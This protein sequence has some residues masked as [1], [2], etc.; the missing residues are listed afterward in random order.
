MSLWAAPW[1][2]MHDI[3]L[4]FQHDL[5]GIERDGPI[6]AGYQ[7]RFEPGNLEK[8]SPILVRRLYTVSYTP[9]RA[10][11]IVYI[12]ST[13]HDNRNS[14]SPSHQYS[15]MP[16]KKRRPQGYKSKANEPRRRCRLAANASG[17][18]KEKKKELFRAP[19][20]LV[21][22]LLLLDSARELAPDL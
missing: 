20:H 14:S 21:L 7:Q 13:E 17:R 19:H 2:D 15:K 6:D 1:G 4:I 8:K 3:N 12:I 18:K 9:L 16:N 22:A 5:N 11:G 10:D